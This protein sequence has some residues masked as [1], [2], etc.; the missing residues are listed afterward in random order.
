MVSFRIAIAASVVLASLSTLVAAAAGDP[1]STSAHCD[2]SAPCCSDGGVCGTGAQ[3][4]AG[5][6]NPLYS[7]AP[8]SCLPEPVCA[9][10]NITFH[11][12]SYNNASVFR[13][14]LQYNGNPNLAPFTLDSGSLGKGPQGVLAQMTA[15]RQVK[16]STTRHMLYGD[17]EVKLR[18]NATVGV[19]MAFITMSSIK[20]EIDW[21]F[22]TADPKNAQTNYFSL[23]IPKLGNGE[24]VGPQGLDVSQWN[25]YGLNWQADRLQWRINGQVVRTLKQSDAGDSYP[26]S[27]SRIQLSV[28]AGGNATLPEGTRQWAGGDIS[29]DTPEYKANG[30]YAMEMASFTMTCAPTST[31]NVPTQGSGSNIT[32]WVYTGAND[33]SGHPAFVLSTDPI[34]YLKN[35]SAQ[36]LPGAPGYADEQTPNTKSGNMWDGS[37]DTGAQDATSS[38]SSGGGGF[39]KHAA[40]KY[41]V[42]IA[43]GVVGAIALWAAIMVCVRRR[44]KEKRNAAM[45]ASGMGSSAKTGGYVTAGNM[46]VSSAKKGP[47]GARYERLG[48]AQYSDDMLPM[49]AESRGSGIGP[50]SGPRPGERVTFST[51]PPRSGGRGPSNSQG[52]SH[53][54]RY[55]ASP[56][57]PVQYQQYTAQESYAMT[58]PLVSQNHGHQNQNQWTRVQTPQ[59][60]QSAGWGSGGGYGYGYGYGDYTQQTGP[61]M[62]SSHGHSGYSDGYSSGHGPQ[63]YGHNAYSTPRYH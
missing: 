60:Q 59:T 11:P 46:P 56:A 25:T 41:G 17:V 3:F 54:A 12:E 47:G 13:P 30:W 6:C 19:V 61:A 36:G 28:W 48:G 14:I 7:H 18:H 27:P 53:G 45:Q 10:Q 26:R 29:Y 22:T 4:C 1:C 16:L 58:P 42:P 15:Q 32:S 62:Q 38:K 55:M 31:A 37:G 39:N 2:S 24:D 49:G 52:Y 50:A 44:R 8:D 9:P 40:L 5:G 33:T 20:D 35:P 34:T 57:T 21:E 51:P 23:G 43:A 63:S